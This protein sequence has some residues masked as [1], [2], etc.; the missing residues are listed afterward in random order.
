MAKRKLHWTQ[1][2]EGKAKMKEIMLAHHAH[3][4]EK[5]S[6]DN[7]AHI[8]YL[9]GKVET[10]IEYYARSNNIPQSTLAEG[11]ASLLRH[12]QGR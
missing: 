8:S 7:Q 11:V 12:S 1:T 4:K 9:Y 2:P 3:Y 10:I 5:P 6:G